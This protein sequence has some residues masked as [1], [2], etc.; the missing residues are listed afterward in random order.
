MNHMD[1]ITE[2]RQMIGCLKEH[3]PVKDEQNAALWAIRR[4]YQDALNDV[5]ACLDFI[6]KKHEQL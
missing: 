3:H 2:I 4:G 6:V 5:M 1:F